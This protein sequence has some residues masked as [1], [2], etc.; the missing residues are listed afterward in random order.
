LVEQNGI[1]FAVYEREDEHKY[2]HHQRDWSMAL[3]WGTDCLKNTLPGHL[4]DRFDE[5]KS[6]PHDKPGPDR[7][8]T[9]P[10]YNGKTGELVA[11]IPGGVAVRV[12]REK[13]RKFLS[14]DIDITVSCVIEHFARL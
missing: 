11:K 7:I 4:L 8:G 6:D 12:N 5:I 10:L 14:N 9:L 3:L 13:L 1:K 2:T